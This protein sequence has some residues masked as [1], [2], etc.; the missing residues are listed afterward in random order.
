MHLKTHVYS[1]ERYSV[2]YPCLKNSPFFNVKKNW[3]ARLTWKEQLGYSRLHLPAHV[4]VIVAH[5]HTYI[6]FDRIGHTSG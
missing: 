3:E 2:I 4:I 1:I 5:Y 6:K